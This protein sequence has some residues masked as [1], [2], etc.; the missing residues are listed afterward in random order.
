M[1]LITYRNSIEKTKTFRIN[2]A[3]PYALYKILFNHEFSIRN[4]VMEGQENI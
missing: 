1:M 3:L 2:P 4:S